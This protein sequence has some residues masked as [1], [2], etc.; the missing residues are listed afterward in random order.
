VKSAGRANGKIILL[1][2]HAVVYGVPALVAGMKRGARA[3][4]SPAEVRT[5]S[6]QGLPIAPPNPLFDAL[7]Q[8]SDLLGLGP[9]ALEL[10]L[11]LPP[12]SGLG[13]SA[14]LGAATVRALAELVGREDE[15]TIWRAVMAWERI[16]HKSPSGVDAIAALQGGVLRYVRGED[17][18]SVVLARPLELSVCIAGPPASTGTMVESVARLRAHKP[19]AF[20][21]NLA[22]IAQ[23]V[24]N[25]AQALRLGDEQNLGRLMDLNHMLLS[26]WM[27]STCELETARQLARQAGAF[28]SKLTGSGGGGAVIAVGPR[29]PILDAWRSQGYSC[30]TAEIGA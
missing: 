1:G 8:V 23:L 11:D 25:A 9:V 12:G 30:F 29:V 27:L 17:P 19:E 6:V 21:K 4:A 15:A 22:A 24:E 7:G 26:S 28:G 10:E 2:E 20:A 3:T 18:L 13:A 16:F 5:I 14:A